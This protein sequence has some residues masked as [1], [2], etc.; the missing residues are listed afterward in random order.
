MYERVIPRDLFNE[1]KLL[2]CLGQLA[3]LIHDGKGNKDLVL[4]HNQQMNAGFQ[5]DQDQSDGSLFCVNI[6]FRLKDTEIPIS[7]SLNSKRPYPMI[8]QDDEGG[9]EDLFNDDGSFTDSFLSWI[10][11][12]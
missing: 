9:E 5:I 1:S 7:T 3:L 8:Y 11:T 2:K 10:E 6:S 12:L 4:E